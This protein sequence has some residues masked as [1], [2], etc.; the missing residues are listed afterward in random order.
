MTLQKVKLTN[1]F[2]FQWKKKYGGEGNTSSSLSQEI[3]H[4][5]V[6]KSRRKNVA[7]WW[8][9]FSIQTW[10]KKLRFS[11][12][13]IW[14]NKEVKKILC[15]LVKCTKGLLNFVKDLWFIDKVSKWQIGF[16]NHILI[17]MVHIWRTTYKIS[18]YYVVSQQFCSISGSFYFCHQ[19]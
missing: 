17:N 12:L 1:T 5:K 8:A 16:L 9:F 11:S 3:Q 14:N 6:K 10:K 2:C 18:L 7:T 19:A 13:K 4:V 15:I